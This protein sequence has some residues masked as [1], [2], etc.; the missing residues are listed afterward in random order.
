[1]GGGELH[2]C[3]LDVVSDPEQALQLLSEMSRM[4]PLIQVV[5]AALSSNDPDRDAQRPAQ[6]A[7]SDFLIQPFTGEQIEEGP[8][9]SS[10]GPSRPERL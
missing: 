10:P 8:C 2:L 1:M 3:F 4:G 7:L 9:R 6:L 5:R